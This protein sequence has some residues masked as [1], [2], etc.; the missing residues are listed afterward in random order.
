[1]RFSRPYPSSVHGFE[2]SRLERTRN[3]GDLRAT[4]VHPIPHP[5]LRDISKRNL[6]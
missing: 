3:A 6:I 1:M 2:V 5:I 4:P